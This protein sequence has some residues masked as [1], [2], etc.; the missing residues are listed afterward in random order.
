MHRTHRDL[1]VRR[2]VLGTL[3]SSG[4]PVRVG[5]LVDL[6]APWFGPDVGPKRLSD[7]LRHQ[8]RMGRVRRVD[9]GLYAIVPG[10]VPRTT[11]WRCVNWRHEVERS[12][13]RAPTGW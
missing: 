6:L 5:E 1:D 11:A 9:R 10:A 12:S 8:V 3:L 2:A 4:S 13:H 7:L